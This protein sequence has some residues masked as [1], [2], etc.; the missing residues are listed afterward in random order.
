MHVDFYERCHS[1]EM[2]YTS[3]RGSMA[4]PRKVS[5]ARKARRFRNAI[6]IDLD[7][8][9]PYLI[10]RVGNTLVQLFSRDLAQFDI[11]VPMWR[12][13]AV[14]GETG[15]LR[16]VDLSSMTSI[17]ASTLSRLTE[18]MQRQKLLRRSRSPQ[19]K[20]EIVIS[21]TPKGQQLLKVL[22]PIAAAYERE[23]TVGL[24]TSDLATTRETLRQ[25]F[26]RLAELKS[27]AAQ[28]MSRS[29]RQ[30]PVLAKDVVG[31]SREI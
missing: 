3:K 8:Y 15:S 17:D 9:L 29:R 25:M 16:L 28:E 14:L 31:T 21:T 13:I 2:T 27:K 30:M 1:L 12:V 22:T 23:M 7:Q 18:T 4:H 24:S 26:A 6:L 20:R 10:N 19:N 5:S 11:S